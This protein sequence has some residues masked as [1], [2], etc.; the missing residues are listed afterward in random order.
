MQQRSL[1]Q[2]LGKNWARIKASSYQP[3]SD[4]HVL[5]YLVSSEAE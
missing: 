3:V 5:S 4:N 2:L 1:E